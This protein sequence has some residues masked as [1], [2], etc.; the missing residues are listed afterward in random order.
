VHQL[1]FSLNEQLLLN[2]QEG[3]R[4]PFTLSFVGYHLEVAMLEE[5]PDKQHLF[6][7]V[8]TI[9]FRTVT[10]HTKDLL[11]DVRPQTH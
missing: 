10:P 3:L 4:T 5:A 8:E 9:T 7:K 2:P 1:G 6:P 11:D